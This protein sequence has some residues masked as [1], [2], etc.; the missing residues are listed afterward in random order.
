MLILYFMPLLFKQQQYKIYKTCHIGLQ[1][2]PQ[3]FIGRV[4][5]Y[6][7]LKNTNGP[8]SLADVNVP[9]PLP[10]V[11]PLFGNSF[12]VLVT[13]AILGFMTA[14]LLIAFIVVLLP[15]GVPGSVPRLP[16][17]M[18]TAPVGFVSVVVVT[19][20][21]AVVPVFVVFPRLH[22]GGVA[23]LLGF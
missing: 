21:G 16:V 10:S 18:L 23:A 1:C 13:V 15:I 9:V 22:V 11:I 8:K 3:R 2:G 7:T 6:K 17:P 20:R 19:V 4:L 14:P 12:S 5:L